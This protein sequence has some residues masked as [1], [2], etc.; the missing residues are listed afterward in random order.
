MCRPAPVRRD[1]CSGPT[2]LAAAALFEAPV[3]ATPPPL[4]GALPTGLVA[5]RTRGVG[6]P[7]VGDAVTVAVLGAGW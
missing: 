2:T 4:A 3:D 7:T 5:W 6:L 1:R